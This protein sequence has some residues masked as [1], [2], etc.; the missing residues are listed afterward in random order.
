MRLILY[1]GKGGVGKTTTSAATAVHAAELGYRTLVVSTDV[2]HSLA[3]ALDAPLGPLPTQ[4][5]ER[6]WGQEINVLDEVRQ[7]AGDVVEDQRRDVA[8]GRVAERPRP[9]SRTFRRVGRR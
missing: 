8:A 9:W 1:L 6:L 5:G 3:D 2:A 4:L 7:P